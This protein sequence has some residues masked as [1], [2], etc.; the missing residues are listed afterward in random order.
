MY[1]VVMQWLFLGHCPWNN[2]LSSL[3]WKRVGVCKNNQFLYSFVKVSTASHILLQ[4]GFKF[5]VFGCEWS[6][7]TSVGGKS[8]NVG[9]HTLRPVT[10]FFG[11]V[12]FGREMVIGY[13][14]VKTDCS[15]LGPWDALPHFCGVSLS[16]VDKGLFVC[17][18][19]LSSPWWGL[20]SV[21]LLWQPCNQ[22]S[23]GQTWCGVWSASV[24]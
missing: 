3:H 7:E 14:S 9:Y 18:V 6:F 21:I 2:S 19:Q 4:L 8:R 23:E 20:Y 22:T 11:D 15:A 17:V 1:A 24:V 10:R 12:L 13:L 16:S 5:K